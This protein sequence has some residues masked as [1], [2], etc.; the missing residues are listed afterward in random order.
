MY[1][2]LTKGT[3][4]MYLLTSKKAV[5]KIPDNIILNPDH[6]LYYRVNYDT[7]MLNNIK[8]TVHKSSAKLTTQDLI[9]LISDQFSLAAANLTNLANAM[10]MTKYLKVSAN[11]IYSRQCNIHNTDN[12]EQIE[13]NQLPSVLVIFFAILYD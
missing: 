6:A 8:K 5:V 2:T 7:S 9:G 10:D 12:C 4:G 3:V 1:K 13:S 11:S